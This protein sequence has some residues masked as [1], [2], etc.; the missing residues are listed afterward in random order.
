M[1]PDRTFFWMVLLGL[2]LWALGI[3][4]ALWLIGGI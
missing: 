3:F 1:S 2:T 4:V